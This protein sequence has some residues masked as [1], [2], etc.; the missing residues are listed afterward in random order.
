[1]FDNDL[2]VIFF[3]QN[4]SLLCLA[5]KKEKIVADTLSA[6]SLFG[7]FSIF[8]YRSE[9][10]FSFTSGQQEKLLCQPILHICKISTK[11]KKTL[12]FPEQLMVQG[13]KL[14]EKGK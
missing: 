10:W 7:V 5:F 9:K 13:R 1:M 2:I 14:G 3:S 12:F 4:E 8:C 6:V 11:F